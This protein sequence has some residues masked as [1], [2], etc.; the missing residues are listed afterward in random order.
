MG[1]LHDARQNFG[2]IESQRRV[3]LLESFNFFLQCLDRSIGADG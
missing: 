3:A 2:D 1:V